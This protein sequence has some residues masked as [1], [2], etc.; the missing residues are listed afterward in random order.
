[1][2]FSLIVTARMLQKKFIDIDQKGAGNLKSTV[3]D[4]FGIP[5]VLILF[6]QKKFD[7]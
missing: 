2:G 7:K 5:S 4:Y 6:S 3:L 1:M